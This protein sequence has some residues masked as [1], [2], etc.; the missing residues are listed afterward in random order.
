MG[1]GKEG[2]EV[3]HG[4]ELGVHLLVVARG[5]VAAERT[6]T[7]LLADGVDG[8]EPHDIDTHLVQTGQVLAGSIESS[9][10]SELADVHFIDNAA[11]PIGLVG[12]NGC[13]LLALARDK[14]GNKDEENVID[15]F[16]DKY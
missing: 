14:Q 11:M 13:F 16:H 3:G 15:F 12:F 10:G 4:A 2:I 9:L 8:H 7:S 1:I 5:I 6:L